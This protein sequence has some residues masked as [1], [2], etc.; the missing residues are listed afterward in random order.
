MNIIQLFIFILLR[1]TKIYSYILI[2]YALLSWFPRLYSTP[3]GRLIIWLAKPFLKP[4]Y[5][6]NLQFFGIDWTVMVALLA[7]QFGT[8]VLLHI[9]LLPW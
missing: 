2:I 1:F 8:R 4:F 3:V 9:L 7:I 5:K 6:L